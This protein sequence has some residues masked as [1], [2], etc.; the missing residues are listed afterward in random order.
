MTPAARWATQRDALSHQPTAPAAATSLE[1]FLRLLRVET[2]QH[3][4]GVV[5]HGPQAV[6][7]VGLAGAQAV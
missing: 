5:V 1:R 2:G 4:L 7:R 3:T 6:Q